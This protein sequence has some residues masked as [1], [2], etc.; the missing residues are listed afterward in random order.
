MTLEPEA[1]L[2]EDPGNDLPEGWT[3][4]S[5]L[6]VSTLIRGVSYKKGE[7]STTPGDGLVPLL[8]ANNIAESLR[9]ED[10]Q[11]VPRSCVSDD[12]LLRPGDV[13]VAMSSGSR[14]VVGK[15]ARLPAAW[16]GTFGAFCAVL[17]PNE[18]VEP[19]YFA[20]YFQTVEYRRAISDAAAGTNI[21][22][23]KRSHFDEL[24]LPLPPLPE[25]RRIVD[26]V[27]TLLAEVNA[28]REGLPASARS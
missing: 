8:R 16:H 14:R 25:Q 2:A 22:N 24:R 21:N 19:A 1:S 15:A 28:A 12:Q 13:V 6:A 18:A 10:L 11:Y 5:P 7:A 27:E 9:F 4:V 26:Q 23:V 17:R 3:T 20:L